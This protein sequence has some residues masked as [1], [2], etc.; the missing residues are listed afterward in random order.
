MKSDYCITVDETD[1]ITG[2]CS[3]LDAHVF[4]KE[5]VKYPYYVDGS[6]GSTYG[7]P[8]MDSISS[9]IYNRAEPRGFFTGV[10][11]DNF[12]YWSAFT[13]NKHVINSNYIFYSLK[14]FICY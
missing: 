10:T 12:T 2:Y 5:N 13:D 7:I 6:S 11:I 8:Y 14:V 4:N 1:K 3:K 9:P